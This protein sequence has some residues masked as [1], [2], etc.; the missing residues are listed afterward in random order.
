MKINFKEIDGQSLEF[1]YQDDGWFSWPTNVEKGDAVAEFQLTRTDDSLVEFK[2]KLKGGCKSVCDRCGDVVQ[3]IIAEEFTYLLNSSKEDEIELPEKECDL[4]E[5]TT[6]YLAD[7][8]I[9]VDHLLSEESIISM[10]QQILCSDS[11]EGICPGCGVSLNNKPCQCEE[12]YS[13]SPFA[14]LKKL[15]QR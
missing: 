8:N 6:L 13:D 4:T 7:D 1:T 2:G 12:D 9:D 10:P 3:V 14:V 15:S 11:C 5:L